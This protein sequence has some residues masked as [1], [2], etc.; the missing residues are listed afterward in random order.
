[1]LRTPHIYFPQSIYKI[2]IF[3]KNTMIVKIKFFCTRER[4]QYNVGDV[5][6][7]KRQDLNHLLEEEA[8]IVI[9]KQDKRRRIK[10]EKK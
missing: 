2:S 3:E 10:L 9:K 7:G 8:P 5:Y 6:T 4:K 1:M